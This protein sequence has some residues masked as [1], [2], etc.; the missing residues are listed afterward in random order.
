M[1]TMKSRSSTRE[2]FWLALAFAGLHFSFMLTVRL[3][4]ARINMDGHSAQ[5]EPVRN[6]VYQTTG[7]LFDVTVFPIGNAVRPLLVMIGVDHVIPLDFAVVAACFGVVAALAVQTCRY[8]IRRVQGRAS[9]DA[10]V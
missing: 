1:K 5:E 6:I 3:A 2:M 7:I 4:W 9:P 8:F 10:A